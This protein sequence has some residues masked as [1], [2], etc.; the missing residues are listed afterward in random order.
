MASSPIGRVIGADRRWRGPGRPAAWRIRVV[1][2]SGLLRNREAS[3]A[4]DFRTRPPRD[5]QAAC[6]QDSITCSRLWARSF[7]PL[8]MILQDGT[9]RGTGNH[10]EG[11][12]ETPSRLRAVPL[13]KLPSG[14]S[15]LSH[16]NRELA[17]RLNGRP[18]PVMRLDCRPG[19]TGVTGSPVGQAGRHRIRPAWLS[20]NGVAGRQRH[21]GCG[22]WDEAQHDLR[23]LDAHAAGGCG[24]GSRCAPGGRFAAAG[25]VLVRR[26]GWPSS[27]RRWPTSRRSSRR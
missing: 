26:R 12:G 6:Y 4:G 1:C 2:G 24:P 10:A 27:R 8:S 20:G 19:M 18:P 25:Q 7:A 13:S 23:L 15:C 17:H 3:R 22:S 21:L 11:S 9:A 5:A 16:L 14:S